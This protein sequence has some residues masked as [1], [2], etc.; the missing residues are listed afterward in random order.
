VT[1]QGEHEYEVVVQ[2]LIGPAVARVLRPCAV[3]R[4][5][6]QTVLEARLTAMSIADLVEW[7]GARGLVVSHVAVVG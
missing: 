7:L 6:E 3:L 1:G 4:A 2:G 5:E